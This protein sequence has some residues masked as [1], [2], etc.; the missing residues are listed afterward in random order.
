MLPTFSKKRRI[1]GWKMTTR[2]SKPSSTALL[3]IKLMALRLNWYEIHM[4][5]TMMSS[6]LATL[7]A[8]VRWKIPMHL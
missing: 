8:L 2:A 3:K 6:A 5:T 7:A 1:S 4:A